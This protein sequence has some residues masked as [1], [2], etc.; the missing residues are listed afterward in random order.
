MVPK[1]PY[2]ADFDT[3]LKGLYRIESAGDP[4]AFTQFEAI[5]ARLAFPCFDEPRFKTPF[6][7]TL[8]IPGEQFAGANTPVK[9]AVDLPDGRQRIHYLPTPNLPTYLIAWAVG[10]L[11]VVSGQPLPPNSVRSRPVPFRGIAAKGQGPR[12]A[13]ALKHTSAFVTFMEEY[14]GIPYPYRKLDIV[15]VPDFSSGAM[16]NVGLITFR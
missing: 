3:Q 8:T 13:Y 11:D 10:P 2:T 16:E 5:N 15:A 1:Q 9:T 7:V 4:Y 14:F 6:D 12:L